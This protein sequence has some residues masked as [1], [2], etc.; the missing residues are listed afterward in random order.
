MIPISVAEQNAWQSG[1]PKNLTLN[2]PFG[3]PLT[4]DDI[5]MESAQLEQAICDESNLTFGM[6]YS[7]CFTVRIFDTGVSYTGQRVLP[8]LSVTDGN[9][10]YTRSFGGYTV[11][12]DKLTSDKLY[13]DLVCY[14]Y[15]TDVLPVSFVQWHNSRPATFTMKQYRDA[16]F[17]QI[18]LT[19]KSINLPNDNVQIK[20]FTVTEL[21][22]ADILACILQLNGA[23]G[24]IDYDGEF[25]YVLPK[26]TPDYTIDDNSFVQGSLVYEDEAIKP[27]T[28]VKIL[29]Y[30]DDYG[31]EGSYSV[32]D[33]SAGN[34][35]GN[36]LVLE[37][38]SLIQACPIATR[39]TLCTN[40]YNSI[41]NY[42][43]YPTSVE[44]PVYIGMEPGDVFK[45]ET[46]RKDITFPVFKRTLKGITSLMDVVEAEGEPDLDQTSGI[47]GG[48]S[49]TSLAM[50]QMRDSVAELLAQKASIEAQDA[51]IAATIA[52]N[53]ALLELSIVQ[54]V[55]GTLNWIREYGD[56]IVTN[57][58]QV[59]PHTIYFTKEGNSYVPIA[60]PDPGANPHALGWYVLDVSDSQ[61]DFIMAHLAVTNAGLWVL[62]MGA[63][64]PHYLV[65]SDENQLVD[66]NND[67]L[68][69]W[70]KDP[71]NA[72]GYKLLLANNGMSIYDP[73]GG[74]VANYGT[75]ITIG[76]EGTFNVYITDEEMQMRNGDTVLAEYG[77][78]N[79]TFYKPDGET[80]AAQIGATGLIINSGNA[81]GW[82]I[83]ATK[84]FRNDGNGNI[85]NLV[86]S[87]LTITAENPYGTYVSQTKVSQNSIKV[88]N[89]TS[90]YL[91]SATFNGRSLVI[92]A[93]D[94]KP[95]IALYGDGTS[96]PEFRAGDN[97]P[98]LGYRYISLYYNLN[99]G[100]KGLYYSNQV[101][102]TNEYAPFW[103]DSN[104]NIVIEAET[105]IDLDLKTHYG[106]TSS[107]VGRVIFYENSDD[108]NVLFR[109][110]GDNKIYLGSSGNR[111]KTGYAV[112]W[113]TT[114]DLKRKEVIEDHD[115][116]IDEFIQ[117]LKPI[118]YKSKDGDSGRIHMG[119]GSQDVSK[120]A[121]DL[122]IGDLS[123]YQADIISD[124]GENKAYHGEDIDD[125]KL[126]WGLNYNEFIAPMVLEI[127]RLMNRVKE[128]EDR[129]NG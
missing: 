129:L 40:L 42:T 1:L 14:D 128:L 3:S 70:S 25:R 24:Y 49:S 6:V 33:A 123:V 109:P 91:S 72:E 93:I 87:G 113:L 37:N 74:V 16:F 46:D 23:F 118:A 103:I 124:E 77:G 105:R 80:V 78:S 13:R 7:S 79:T 57:D 96:S 30:T 65:D 68:V 50:N 92:D 69:D 8:Q 5:Y 53:S 54:D 120:L 29:G 76:N 43:Y 59:M 95:Y 66:S 45:I 60:S 35:T 20:K 15:L 67:S 82:T 102:G 2:F 90:D 32:A 100:N 110:D 114:S 83:D 73:T 85:V 18:Q 21:T 94:G 51:A 107:R 122:G 27:I 126:V 55:S 4:N 101:T 61:A 10:T 26:T 36:V 89:Y 48:V 71:E 111:W 9:V 115:W 31:E 112:Q 106:Q 75:E 121:R 119:F 38:N 47:T 28:G 44:L 97:S 34:D 117:G 22:G 127:Q 17:Q 58:T 41:K 81:G 98:T 63:L 108:G 52:A 12:S 116:K 125:D 11:K 99:S 88:E 56:Y 62:P 64:S 84:L 104:D 86:S 19:Q 39:Q